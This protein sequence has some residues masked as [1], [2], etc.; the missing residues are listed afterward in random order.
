MGRL[1]TMRCLTGREVSLDV[2]EDQTVREFREQLSLSLGML[3]IR[4]GVAE[5]GRR[6]LASNQTVADLFGV[7]S[8]NVVKGG[9]VRPQRLLNPWDLDSGLRLGAL[10]GT[11]D[12]KEPAPEGVPGNWDVDAIA[13]IET[14]YGSGYVIIGYDH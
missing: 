11:D 12:Q 2:D 3:E 4:K 7:G 14:T 10:A 1:R 5:H 9:F 8:Q 13:Y 6:L